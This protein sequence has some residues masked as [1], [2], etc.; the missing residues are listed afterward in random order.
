MAQF[1]YIASQPDGRIVESELEAQQVSD[2]LQFLTSRGLKPISV[3]LV[4]RAKEER[5]TLFRG[6]VTIT[7][8]IFLFRYLT[9]MLQIGTN[10][11]Q[12]VN[13]LIDDFEP[14][15]IVWS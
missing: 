14:S 10:L 12:A 5:K 7:D 9:L 11:L 6:R 15:I 8:Q 13:I 2:V 1:H 3:K 4:E